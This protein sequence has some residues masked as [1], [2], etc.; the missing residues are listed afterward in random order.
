MRIHT[1][2]KVLFSVGLIFTQMS[3]LWA[4]GM[5]PQSSIIII[6]ESDGEGNI[7]VRNTDDFPNLLVTKIENIEED[8]DELI[9]V[10]PPVSRVEANDT[11]TVRFMITTKEPIKIERLKR[12]IFE[13]I[14]PK[15]SELNKEVNVTFSQNL[16]I[17]IRPAGLAKNLSPWEGLNWKVEGKN[18]IVKNPSP[19]VVRFIS[20]NVEL[21]PSKK[22]VT[23]PKTYILPGQTLVLDGADTSSSI[24]NKTIRYYPATTW[25]FSAGKY[26]DVAL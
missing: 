7:D 4:A 14:P 5:V 22:I 6:E 23:L 25:G 1:S 21:L 9:T 15:N 26:F 13:G 20:P 17:L 24:N 2:L 19:Y 3:S 11:Q 12:V 16:P 18:I 10:F 8:K